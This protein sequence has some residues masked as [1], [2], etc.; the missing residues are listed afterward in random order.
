MTY[1]YSSSGNDSHLLSQT[2]I[3]WGR[4]Q[5]AHILGIYLLIVFYSLSCR[6]KWEAIDQDN[7]VR[8]TLK[9]C[10]SSPPTS[11]GADTAMC[12]RNLTTNKEQ[13]VGEFSV[14]LVLYVGYSA[15]QPAHCLLAVPPLAVPSR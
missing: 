3:L 7:K 4:G 1:L 5:Q 10:D 15:H 14:C 12:L 13:S 11:C 9:L 6:Y 8:Y 2:V